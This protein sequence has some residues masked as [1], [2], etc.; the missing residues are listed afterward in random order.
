MFDSISCLWKGFSFKLREYRQAEKVVWILFVV[1]ITGWLTTAFASWV[2]LPA[3]LSMTNNLP[4][5]FYVAMFF[6][7]G[8]ASVIYFMLSYLA[9]YCV[10]IW[11][12]VDKKL[13][14]YTTVGARI[15][16][17]CTVV[18]LSADAYMNWKG[19]E[20]RAKENSGTKQ[21]FAYQMSATDAEDLKTYKKDLKD[22]LAGKLGGYG[23]RDPKTKIY[24]TNRSGKKY[25][26]EISS[27]I[28][29]IQQSDSTK[30]A[31]YIISMNANNKLVD[32][33]ELRLKSTLGNAVK[34]VYAFMLMLCIAQAFCVETIQR[35]AAPV[36]GKTSGGSSG[37]SSAKSSPKLSINPKHVFR[38][39]G[40][41]N[42]AITPPIKSATNTRQLH[43]SKAPNFSKN[44][45]PVLPRGIDKSK[46]KKLVKYYHKIPLKKDGKPNILALSN[47]T[48]IA[49]ATVSNYIDIAINRGDIKT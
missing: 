42:S 40:L 4:Y 26:R 2:S 12:S 22:L 27:N 32:D 37:R 44:N 13:R 31:Q 49:R 39:M 11:L 1:F 6:T 25:Q 3:Y 41:A 38:K 9:G 18:F 48:G 36:F 24:H 35:K 20:V 10:E 23:W 19:R 34:G 16:L 21:N 17:A 29:R 7:I 33:T 8:I 5:A 45:Q 46:Y 28:R 14:D 43:Q 30:Q 47:K 15:F